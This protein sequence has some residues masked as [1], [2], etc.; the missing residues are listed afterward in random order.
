MN[1]LWKWVL[2]LIGAALGGFLWLKQ[3]EKGIE[4]A[5]LPPERPPVAV[6]TR[7]VE[8]PVVT[9]P[10]VVQVQTPEPPKVEVPAVTPPPP[11]K[12]PG[13][14][15][16]LAKETDACIRNFREDQIL[17]PTSGAK[18][19]DLTPEKDYFICSAA[20]RHAP[21]TCR[22][23][24]LIEKDN[25]YTDKKVPRA[26]LCRLWTGCY[27]YQKALVGGYADRAEADC[28]LCLQSIR[29]MLVLGYGEA[30]PMGEVPAVCRTWKQA[31]AARDPDAVCAALFPG[32]GADPLCKYRFVMDEVD[33]AQ[34][35]MDN[36]Q[37]FCR[38]MGAI[39]TSN[40]GACGGDLI[41]KAV[42]GSAETCSEF[43]LMVAKD[44]CERR[45]T[46]LEVMPYAV[47]PQPVAEPKSKGRTKRK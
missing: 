9:P 10:P 22:K 30:P 46:K 33:C 40:A 43:M 44:H 35:G 29:E 20:A 28:A 47:T 42:V 12:D 32:L 31:Y 34:A 5:P 24:D 17:S 41:C 18:T 15:M 36:D 37:R 45:S 26:G 38:T 2:L 7:P 8:T 25:P 21:D 14:E 16:R 1:A 13:K 19:G 39:R 27:N 11:V 6:E 23:V 3:A 4:V